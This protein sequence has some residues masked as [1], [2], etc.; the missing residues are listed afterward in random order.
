M[1]KDWIN[2]CTSNDHPD[3]PKEPPEKGW[4]P[5]RLIDLG[6]MVE[7]AG[8]RLFREDPP[9]IRLDDPARTEEKERTKDSGYVRLVENKYEPGMT[10]FYVTLS[11]CWGI[12]EMPTLTRDTHDEFLEVIDPE[13]LLRTF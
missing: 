9:Q 5:T 11:H 10:G 13:S 12:S 6:A 7:G 3:C 1:A 2:K 4:Y 8:K